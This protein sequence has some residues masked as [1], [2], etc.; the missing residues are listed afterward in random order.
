MMNGEVGSPKSKVMASK[1]GGKDSSV[2]NG[3]KSFAFG[4]RG[5]DNG[6]LKV[7]H[8]LISCLE[9]LLSHNQVTIDYVFIVD[10]MYCIVFSFLIHTHIFYF[11]S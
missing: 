6:S 9:H 11:K 5:Q 3:N 7:F 4:P 1:T 8:V 2:N 10:S